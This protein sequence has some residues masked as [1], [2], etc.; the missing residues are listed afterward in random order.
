MLYYC[1]LFFFLRYGVGV[2]A[3]GTSSLRL[4][5]SIFFAVV[6]PVSFAPGT[7]QTLRSS[8]T[9]S[10]GGDGGDYTVSGF[11][12]EVGFSCLLHNSRGSPATWVVRRTRYSTV[13]HGV[14]CGTVCDIVNWYGMMVRFDILYRKITVCDMVCWW[15]GMMIRCGGYI[16]G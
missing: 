3:R 8:V 6:M 1:V 4:L 14:R 10:L 2:A 12:N 5:D 13:W 15:Y 7:S 9:D 16:F 11:L